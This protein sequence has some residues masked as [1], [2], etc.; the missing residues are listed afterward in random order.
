MHK[1]TKMREADSPAYPTAPSHDTYRENLNNPEGVYST[2][3]D[4]WLI[5]E[6]IQSPVVGESV[7]VDRWVRNGQMI[8][9]IF[10]TSLVTKVTE[11]GFETI[12]S[13][14][15]MEEVDDESI[16]DVDLFVK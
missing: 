16:L 6:L 14:Y 2:N 9:G 11:D 8:R 13:V 15:K 4:Y 3:I 12:N 10:H 5:G 7:V 1:I